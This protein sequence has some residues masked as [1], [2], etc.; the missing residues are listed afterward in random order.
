[1][2]SS[3][4]AEFDVLGL[5]IKSTPEADEGKISTKEIVDLVNR[6]ALKI[7][8]KSPGLDN[9]KIAILLALELAQSKLSIERD[10][11]ESVLV[12]HERGTKILELLEEVNPSS[13]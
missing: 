10:L 1:M 7:R 12:L 3:K 4:E 5:R 2:I 9:G 13:L 11:K 8:E 6:E